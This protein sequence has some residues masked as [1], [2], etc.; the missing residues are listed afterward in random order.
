MYRMRI[1]CAADPEVRRTAKN[2]CPDIIDERAGRQTKLPQAGNF[3]PLNKIVS[4]CR[5][6]KL[7]AQSQFGCTQAN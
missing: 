4:V 7:P 6:G 1:L 2:V 5:S 3:V